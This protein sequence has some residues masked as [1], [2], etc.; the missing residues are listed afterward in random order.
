MFHQQRSQPQQMMQSSRPQG[1]YQHFDA[2]ESY[3]QPV[4][5]P[6]AQHRGFL[7]KLVCH[8]SRFAAQFEIDQ[9]R[10]GHHTVKMEVAPSKNDNSKAFDWSQK[11]IIQLTRDDL[12]SVMSVFL[13]QTKSF[14]AKAYGQSN[15]KS[16]TLEYRNHET[17]GHQLFL[18]VSED[19]KRCQVP[20][21]LVLA[22]QIGHLCLTQYI[23]N[24]EGLDCA[25]VY[26]S[27]CRLS[28]FS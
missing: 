13:M 21:P 5:S 22:T 16:F 2:A 4:S 12:L 6:P 27:I 25:T 20:I 15:N 9:T 17:Y 18:M 26:Q 19:K 28:Q 1:N 24:Y 23:K 11:I 8:S 10:K 7:E 3:S 14:K